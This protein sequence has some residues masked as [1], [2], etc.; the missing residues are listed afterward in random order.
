MMMTTFYQPEGALLDTAE[1]K[2]AVATAQSLLQAQATGRIL[3]ARATMCDSS[4]NLWVNLPCMR[5]IIPREE[6][7][8]GIAEGEL[9]DIALIARVGKPVSFCV[10]RIETDENGEPVA[11]L[12]RRMVQEQCMERYLAH[13]Q[14]GDVIDARVTHLEPFGAFVDIG[15]GIVSMVP[16][17]TI[18]VSRIS[19]PSD[20]FTVGQ[21]VRVIIKAV[22]GKRICLSH[23]ELLGTWEENATLSHVGE[24]TCGIVRSVEKYGVFIELMPN[25]AGL[26]E[27]RQPV[28]PGQRT[29][30]YIKALIP[31]KLKVKLILVD[32]C[33]DVATPDPIRYFYNDSHI[34]RWV[35]TPENSGKHIETVF[36]G[37]M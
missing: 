20:R 28:R 21:C 18:S 34:D 13:L 3:E 32:V 16:I 27:L 6:G 24:T 15:C 12:S 36:D 4:H 17:D 8:V 7:A 23:K 29:S 26:A 30:V 1:N 5:G 22:Q 35:Y 2:A 11:V 19:H 9:R 33:E 31:E 25:L 14:P 10:L 37:T